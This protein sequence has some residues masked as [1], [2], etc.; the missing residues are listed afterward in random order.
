MVILS[1]ISIKVFDK[2]L[3]RSPPAESSL[4]GTPQGTRFAILTPHPGAPHRC[5]TILREHA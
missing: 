1:W 5:E 4:P 2:K 3:E